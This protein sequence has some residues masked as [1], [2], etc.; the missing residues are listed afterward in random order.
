MKNCLFLLTLLWLTPVSA[1]L[2]K[3]RDAQGHLIFTD[4]PSDAQTSEIISSTEAK[5][6]NAAPNTTPTTDNSASTPNQIAEKP[7]TYQIEI[8]QPTPETTFHNGEP[9]IVQLKVTPAL[10]KEDTIALSVDGTPYGSPSSALSIT[11][12]NLERGP[13]VLSAQVIQKNGAGATSAAVK[14]YQQRNTT[15]LRP[16]T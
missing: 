1:T 4:V 2:Y 3:Q 12:E 13:H 10:Q 11:V 16:K 6:P 15:L 7:L 8:L 14:I 5:T 9:L